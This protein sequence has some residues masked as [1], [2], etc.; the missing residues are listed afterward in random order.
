MT[1]TCSNSF[2]IRVVSA[3]KQRGGRN[4]E[5]NIRVFRI[6]ALVLV[7]AACSSENQSLKRKHQTKVK[8]VQAVQLKFLVGGQVLGKRMGF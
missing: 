8:I 6:I 1:Y 4:S 7:L 5:K 3:I 2:I